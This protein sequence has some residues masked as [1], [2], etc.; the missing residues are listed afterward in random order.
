MRH[1]MNL[2]LVEA[3]CCRQTDFC[4]LLNVEKVAAGILNANPVL[5]CST[6]TFHFLLFHLARLSN[7]CANC[8]FEHIEASPRFDWSSRI[9]LN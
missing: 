2:G 5:H 9:K 7:R 4:T 3:R 1:S 8:L 6:K